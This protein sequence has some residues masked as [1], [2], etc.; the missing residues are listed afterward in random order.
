VRE[1]IEQFRELDAVPFGV[2][3]ADAES[4]L[5]FIQ[6]FDFPFDLL[7]DEDR[8][9]ATAYDALKP[10]GSG[11]NRTVVAIGKDGRIVFYE[12]GA[13]PPGNILR[14]VRSAK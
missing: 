14:T 10:D 6:A 3:P 7:I 1:T 12:R 9:I 13:P 5:A 4:H 2:N 11:I 8:K